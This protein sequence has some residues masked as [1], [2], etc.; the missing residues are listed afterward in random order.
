MEIITRGLAF[1]GGWGCNFAGNIFMPSR[2][3]IAGLLIVVLQLVGSPASAGD[4]PAPT[5]DVIL[6]VSGNIANTNGNGRAR[7]DRAML[8]SLGTTVLETST[9][10]TDNVVRFDGVLARRVVAAVGGKGKIAI[11]TALNDYKIEIPLSDFSRYDVLLA[12]KMN[13]EYMR[14]RDKGPIWIVYPVDQ[15]PELDNELIRNRWIWQ[16]SKLEIQ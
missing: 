2:C 14:V 7:F 5:G 6:T 15:H 4:L 3:L 1:R 13:G 11:A 12:L 8:E 9:Y 16:L 10:W